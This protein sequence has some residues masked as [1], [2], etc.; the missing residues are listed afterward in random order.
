[1]VFVSSGMEFL[2]IIGDDR[3]SFAV[4]GNL[5]P[6][7]EDRIRDIIPKSDPVVQRDYTPGT[8]KGQ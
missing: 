1:M 2:F 8:I 3:Q 7:M 6:S 5:H 4:G